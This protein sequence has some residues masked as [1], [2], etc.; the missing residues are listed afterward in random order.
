LLFDAEVVGEF[1]SG[2]VSS[3][4]VVAQQR[5]I[6]VGALVG[7]LVGDLVEGILAFRTTGAVR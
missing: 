5:V 7:Q 4:T 3:R 1:A 2:A 6:T